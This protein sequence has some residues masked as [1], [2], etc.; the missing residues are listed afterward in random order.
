M[1]WARIEKYFVWGL[2][3]VNCCGAGLFVAGWGVF[4]AWGMGV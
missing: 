2:K 1:W 3:N 4:V